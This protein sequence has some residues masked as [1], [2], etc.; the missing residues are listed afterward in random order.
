M[1]AIASA[2]TVAVTSSSRRTHIRAAFFL[3]FAPRARLPGAVAVA[4]STS[5]RRCHKDHDK[6]SA[7]IDDDDDDLVLD[8]S[9]PTWDD[10]VLGCKM[11]VLVEFW[12]PWCGPCR[13]MHPIIADLAKACTG[14]LRCFKLNT[15]KNQDVATRYGI[16]SIP[17]I[18]IFKNGERKETVIGAVTDSTLATTVERFL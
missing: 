7:A 9:E 18:L 13:L 6:A 8:V 1:A 15:D 4:A 11:P 17:T 12:A 16:R 5:A 2:E 14:R 3:S 10:L